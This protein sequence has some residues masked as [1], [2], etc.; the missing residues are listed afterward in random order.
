MIAWP[1]FKDSVDLRGS[2]HYPYTGCP[3][4]GFSTFT[5]GV[6]VTVVE[7][8]AV[9]GQPC[10]FQRGGEEGNGMGVIQIAIGYRAEGGGR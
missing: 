7:H 10:V 6:G 8:G 3:L 1:R 2:M 4:V 9:G 5:V